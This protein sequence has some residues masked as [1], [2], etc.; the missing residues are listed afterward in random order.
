MSGEPCRSCGAPVL[1]RRHAETHRWA[2][3]DATPRADG[4][5]VLVLG[6]TDYRAATDADRRQR[7]PAPRFVSHFASCEQADKWRG[8]GRQESLL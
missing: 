1:W 2:P 3:L 4:A 7:V 5:F 8:Q 6:T